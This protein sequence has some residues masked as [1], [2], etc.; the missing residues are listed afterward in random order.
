MNV[1]VIHNER[2]YKAALKR[3]DEIFDARPGTREFSELEVLSVLV[4]HY[5]KEK[6]AFPKSDP[7]ELI[8]FKMFQ[9]DLAPGD[10]KEIGN[11]HTI[12]KILNYRIPVSKKAA[13]L[14]SDQLDI[15]VELLLRPYPLKK[16]LQG[17]KYKL[18]TPLKTGVGLTSGEPPAKY[19][20][21]TKKQKS[22]E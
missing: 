10:L 9:L 22:S 20:K 14:F 7:V 16:S 3:M 2:E 5:E 4:S 17:Q 19:G 21:R 12:W 8:R 6:F 15:P 18:E 1:Q 11:R 13:I